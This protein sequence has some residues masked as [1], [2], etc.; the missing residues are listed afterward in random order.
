[1][2]HALLIVLPLGLIMAIGWIVKRIGL[3]TDT[4]V[5]E[6]NG[7]LYWVSMPAILFR[8]TIKVDPAHFSNFPFMCGVYGVFVVLP[9]ISWA[10]ARIRGLPRE[11]LAV[12][13]LVSI[14]GN[15]VFMGLPAVTIALGEP[16]LVSYGIYLA[17]SLVVYQMISIAM[18]QLALSGELS[19]RSLLKTVRKLAGNPMLGA[20]VLGVT[21]A[22]LGMGNLPGWLDQTLGILGNVG[23][24]V[25]L[26]A[27][28]ASLQI[29]H[30][31]SS[32][33][34]VW[35]DILIRLFLSPL[36]TWGALTFMEVDPMLTKTAVLVAAMPAAV[37]NFVLAQGMGMDGSYAGEVIITTTV[38]SILSL[39][40]WIS[41]LGV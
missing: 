21:G 32:V 41:L 25:A 13:V 14:R 15:N 8:S 35:N 28:G 33:K 38:F 7:M 3:V 9:F 22:F 18:G 2:L 26:M 30:I 11:K 5:A 6:M 36:M 19:I 4:G 37:N 24:G 40:L 12:S 20:C 23:S 10:L 29:E 1:M 17:L 39:T 34:R 27:L 31:L 16:G